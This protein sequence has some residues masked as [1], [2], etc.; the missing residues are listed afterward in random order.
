MC[1]C[2]L[3]K[4]LN[5]NI[6][7]DTMRGLICLGLG[8]D[9]R[10]DLVNGASG[11]TLCR[12]HTTLR[13]VHPWPFIVSGLRT[14]ASNEVPLTAICTSINENYEGRISHIRSDISTFSGGTVLEGTLQIIPFEH[15]RSAAD[16]S[17]AMLL[18]S[19]GNTHDS[20]SCRV[21]R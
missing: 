6:R 21:A 4:K 18:T 14:I 3:A 7:G 11:R 20:F 17:R 15:N 10:K 5:C 2:Y 12:S 9:P 8:H 16:A 19:K 13:S 1:Q